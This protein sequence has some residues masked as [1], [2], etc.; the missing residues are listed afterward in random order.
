MKK[1]GTVKYKSPNFDANIDFKRMSRQSMKNGYVGANLVASTAKKMYIP[2]ATRRTYNSVQVNKTNKGYLI[3]SDN[4][5]N[6]SNSGI[7]RYHYTKP[8]SAYSIAGV[9][10][11]AGKNA[12][13]FKWFDKSVLLVK[14]KLNS[15]MKNGVIK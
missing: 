12:G 8:N 5:K 9:T 11:P 2:I 7:D 13:K 10:V 6:V 4:Y 14:G 1:P 3:S 15:I